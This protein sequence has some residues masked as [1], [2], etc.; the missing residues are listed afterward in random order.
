MWPPDGA[1]LGGSCRAVT[2]RVSS[3]FAVLRSLRELLLKKVGQARP[4]G[5]L[6]MS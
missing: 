5:L 3:F 4:E 6:L 1:G 2:S